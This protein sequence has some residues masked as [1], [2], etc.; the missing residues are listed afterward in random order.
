MGDLTAPV[1]KLTTNTSATV[2]AKQQITQSTIH[3]IS[4][5]VVIPKL[6]ACE[7]GGRDIKIIDTNGYYSYGVLMFQ[8]ATFKEYG[9]KYG[10]VS[11]TI[12]NAQLRVL[13]KQPDTEIKLARQMLLNGLWRNWFNCGKSIG[14]E[15]KTIIQ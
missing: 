2:I 11:S 6:I 7:S 14:L 9:I 5:D 12:T 1:S 13:M 3:D 10:M 8:L 4:V 15:T